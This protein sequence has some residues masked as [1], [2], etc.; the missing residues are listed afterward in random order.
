M[1]L[2]THWGLPGQCATGRELLMCPLQQTL[3]VCDDHMDALLGRRPLKLPGPT[4]C[5]KSH[6]H[7]LQ[8]AAMY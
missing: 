4:T 6:R 3:H 5:C 8:V 7:P 2:D 1:H